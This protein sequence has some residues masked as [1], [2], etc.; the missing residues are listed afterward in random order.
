M[1]LIDN[2]KDTK[3]PDAIVEP[4][5]TETTIPVV[6]C[7]NQK[8]N[9]E[10]LSSGDLVILES[11]NPNKLERYVT[12][13]KLTDVTTV[14]PNEEDD[15]HTFNQARVMM[16]IEDMKMGTYD[17]MLEGTIYKTGQLRILQVTKYQI[18]EP[19]PIS[20]EGSIS[21]P[22]PPNT[23]VY[24]ISDLSDIDLGTWRV[25]DFGFF[26]G[27]DV[28]VPCYLVDNKTWQHDSRNKGFFGGT[29]SGKS[30][31]MAAEIDRN[32]ATDMNMF[33]GD[34]KGQIAHEQ[35]PTSRN[36][37]KRAKKFNRKLN[38]LTLN[39]IFINL[40]QNVFEKLLNSKKLFGNRTYWSKMQSNDRK[41]LVNVFTGVCF[42]DLK[43]EFNKWINHS[44][45]TSELVSKAL[46]IIKNQ[47]IQNV[48]AGSTP[49]NRLIGTIDRAI[50]SPNILNKISSILEQVRIF[51]EKSESKVSVYDIA[52]DLLIGNRTVTVVVPE[53]ENNNSSDNFE[54]DDIYHIFVSKILQEVRNKLRNATGEFKVENG[55]NSAIIIDEA[56]N[57][58]PKTQEDEELKKASRAICE[59]AETYRSKGI[60]TWVA[61][62]SPTL[63]NKDLKNRIF[64]HD[65]YI[66]SKLTLS[67][68]REI[69][70]QI[71]DKNIQAEFDRIPKPHKELNKN[72]KAELKHV[73]FLFKGKLTPLD[74]DEKGIIVRIDLEK[75]NKSDEI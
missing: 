66:G 54:P 34:P 61:S 57:L 6:L 17:T 69:N 16:D 38:I 48:Y 40:D 42:E 59:I 58:F 19:N 70:D 26:A 10:Y 39:D 65:L 25:E 49:Q 2:T 53:V 15:R 75:D 44:Y 13:G 24:K 74:H 60:S 1:K 63:I 20:S 32:F 5:A 45:E 12:L 50:A 29:G 7:I 9:H 73:H 37:K 33:I 30:M 52:K 46:E 11:T 56:Q 28:P 71:T 23:P 14:S 62:P 47:Y 35:L 67:A 22:I 43:E 41:E 72:G 21:D 64:D 68:K 31:L 3:A 51:F 36:F 27:T 55:Y 4:N 8:T 18:G